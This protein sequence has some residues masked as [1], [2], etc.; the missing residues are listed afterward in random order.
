MDYGAIIRKRREALGLTQAALAQRMG[1]APERPAQWERGERLP[2]LMQV[3]MLCA[4]LELPYEDFFGTRARP[5]RR[6]AKP[7]FQ[8]SLAPILCNRTMQDA[9]LRRGLSL[10]DFAAAVGVTPDLAARWEAG[11]AIPP[12]S[13]IPDICEALGIRLRG[14]FE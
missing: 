14:F 7:Y 2:N 10:A 6:S 12:L 4:A 11:R 13:R 3:P 9:R 5:A 8:L 1:V